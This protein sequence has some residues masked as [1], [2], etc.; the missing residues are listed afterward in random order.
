LLALAVNECAGAPC[1]RR[2]EDSRS[3]EAEDTKQCGADE[4]RTHDH[5][6]RKPLGPPAQPPGAPWMLT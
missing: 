6:Q 4:R 2:M 3:G 5:Y 1:V